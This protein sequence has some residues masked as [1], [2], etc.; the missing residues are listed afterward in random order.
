MSAKGFAQ[1]L[2]QKI[3]KIFL[4]LFVAQLAYIIA[5]KWVDP[6]ITVT[7]IVSFVQGYGLKRDYVNR[8]DISPNAALAIIAAA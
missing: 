7:Q 5:L 6:P 1:R 4:I 8:K 3:K 2:G